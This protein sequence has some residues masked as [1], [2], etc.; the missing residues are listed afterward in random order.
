MWHGF[1]GCAGWKAWIGLAAL[2]SSACSVSSDS[3]LPWVRVDEV[4]WTIGDD[5]SWSQIDEPSGQWQVS[6]FS[7]LGGQDEIFWLRAEVTLTD[8]HVN[9]TEPLAVW[10]SALA[11]C[12]LFWDGEALPAHGK[13]G[14]SPQEEIAGPIDAPTF[15]PPRMATAGRHL[16]AGRCSTQHRQ[17]EPLVGFYFLAV[18]TYA[19]FIELAG[20]YSGIAIASLSAK[21]VAAIY[22]L[23]MFVLVRERS[24]LLLGL[25]SLSAGGLLVV[26]AWRS[27]VGYTY[28]WH[29]PRL[30]GVAAFAWLTCAL[31]V[32]FFVTRFRGRY[33]R[34]LLAIC[35]ALSLVAF[36]GLP[37][38]DAKVGAFFAIALVA[39]TVWGVGA[40]RRGLPGSVLATLGVVLCLAV[41]VWKPGRFADQT[42]FLAL[43]GTLALLLVSRA[44]QARDDSRRLVAE[45]LRSARLEAELVKRSIQPH[46][47]MNTL[48][49]LA[50]WFER[51]PEVASEMLDSLSQEM[52][53]LYDIADQRTIP[54]SSELRLCRSHLEVMGY[55][56]DR[57]FRLETTG[58]NVDAPTAPGVL[59]TLLENALTHNRYRHPE[60]VF[61]L[62]ASRHG[63]ATCYRLETPLGE[64][65]STEPDRSSGG[66][67]GTGMRYV[68]TRLEESFGSEVGLISRVEGDV[69]ATE[70]T[71]P[72]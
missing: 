39:S 67:E 59:H 56:Q 23:A 24:Y 14:S 52:R 1:K 34:G 46:F 41:F 47:L 17:R 66:E 7:D 32:L 6:A 58:I 68:R 70:W 22:F 54:W 13:V 4:A 65:L 44:I 48:T 9:S 36:F 2:V 29:F 28:D 10:L 40:I 31:L 35:L 20:A 19:E 8:A 72:A 30:Y 37:G 45:R 3:R 49:A 62:I 5:A 64:A 60:T 55:R 63:A 18:S 21:A 26:E 27:L 53:M 25:L 38:W 11:T 69:W 15:L 51:Q 33:G 16:L 71:V 57:K 61:Q 12:E 42:V 50:E 43:D